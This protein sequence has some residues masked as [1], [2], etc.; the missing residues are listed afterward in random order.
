MRTS[1]A[2]SSLF[3]WL[4]F[5]IDVVNVTKAHHVSWLMY[6]PPF[7]LSFCYKLLSLS[8]PPF[9]LDDRMAFARKQWPQRATGR[10][11]PT[12]LYIRGRMRG[13]GGT[14][15]VN[16]ICSNNE[17]VGSSF[18]STPAIRQYTLC[19]ISGSRFVLKGTRSIGSCI[20]IRLLRSPPYS[21]VGVN[22]HPHQKS[23]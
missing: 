6:T 23:T 2:I 8:F 16:A 3:G 17:E 10:F 11:A 18:I 15:R 21:A 9:W 22:W 20:P 1:A 7:K 13:S 5:E 4:L 12:T 19:S 14:A